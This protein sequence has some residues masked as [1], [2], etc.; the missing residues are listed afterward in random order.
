MITGGC[1]GSGIG[2][3]Q[4][5][6][7]TTWNQTHDNYTECVKSER[8]GVNDSSPELLANQGIPGTSAIWKN[9]AA[10]LLQLGM[11]KA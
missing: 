8:V 2:M 5:I 7:V 9:A 11:E 1:E 10:T 6:R 3:P 4:R